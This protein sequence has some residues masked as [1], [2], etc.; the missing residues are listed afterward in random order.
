MRGNVRAFRGSLTGMPVA[1]KVFS[2]AAA[3]IDGSACFRRAAQAVAWGAEKLVPPTG[4]VPPPSALV[5]IR[6][7]GASRSVEASLLEKQVI[8]S[9]TVVASAQ[10]PKFA[11]PTFAS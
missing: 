4:E 9:A 3:R 7:P 10:K 2:I 1:L 11:G 6:K 5:V 8:L